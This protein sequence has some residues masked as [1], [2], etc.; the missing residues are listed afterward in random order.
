MRKASHLHK[1]FWPPIYIKMAFS[2]SGN[3]FQ[4]GDVLYLIFDCILTFHVDRQNATFGKKCRDHAVI[5]LLV[6]AVEHTDFCLRYSS[7]PRCLNICSATCGFLVLHG[8]LASEYSVLGP[9]IG[10]PK[11]NIRIL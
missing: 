9:L 5:F 3:A 1:L 2:I 6:I 7:H 10:V 11:Q 8:A 4:G